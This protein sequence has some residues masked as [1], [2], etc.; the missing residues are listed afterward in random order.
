MSDH[1]SHF[2]SV[3]GTA[4]ILGMHS[5]NEKGSLHYPKVSALAR[6]KKE[7]QGKTSQKKD[8][9]V[10][11][12]TVSEGE[13]TKYSLKVEIFHFWQEMPRFQQPPKMKLQT[14]QQLNLKV[15]DM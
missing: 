4:I 14:A 6:E 8:D 10:E 13:F 9:K 5:V 3:F 12:A 2:N 11:K 7:L 1:S 15:P